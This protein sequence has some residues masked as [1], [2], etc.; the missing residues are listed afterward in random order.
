M[1]ELIDILDSEGKLT[2]KTAM[3][4]VAHK[5]GLFHQTVHIWFYNQNGEILIQQ[6]GKNKATFPLLWDVSVAGHIG[7][8]ESIEVSALREIEE[9]I[10]LRIS[11]Q[12]LQKIGVFKSI[13]KH[14]DT[15]ID[16]EFHH[17]FLCELKVPI[18]QLTKQESEVEALDFILLDN[19]NKA[20]TKSVLSKKYVPHDE[21]YYETV[22]KAIQNRL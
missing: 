17:T 13:Q 20:L 15:L 3:K 5:E 22:T 21:L 14:N 2:G 6:R 19:L 8:G 10:G 4:S 12:E 1:D 18:E 9:E 16:C 7:A 11:A